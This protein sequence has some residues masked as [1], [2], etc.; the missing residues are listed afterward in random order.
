MSIWVHTPA[1]DHRTRE[2]DWLRKLL[3]GATVEDVSDTCHSLTLRATDGQLYRFSAGGYEYEMDL[4]HVA[5][6][7]LEAS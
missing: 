5:E 1:I 2:A 6:Q 3:R 4:E 7:R